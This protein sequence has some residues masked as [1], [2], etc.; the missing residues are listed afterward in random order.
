[1]YLPEACCDDC[2]RGLPCS[3]PGLG[4]AIDSRLEHATGLGLTLPSFISDVQQTL[5]FVPPAGMS[6]GLDIL[7]GVASGLDFVPGV[8]PLA[9][10]VVSIF[11]SALSSFDHWLHIG[12]GRSEADLIT[13][14]PNHIQ[15]QVMNQIKSISYVGLSSNSV[16]QLQA[17]IQELYQL[18]ASWL[19]FISNTSHFHDGRASEQAANTVMPYLDGT[20]GYHWPPPMNPGQ[21]EGCGGAWATDFGYGAG[22]L[23][24]LEKGLADRGGQVSP[25][26]ITQ[27]MSPF[28]P[29]LQTP[30]PG[31]PEIPQAGTLPPVSPIRTIQS[32]G[33]VPVGGLSS[34]A[35]LLLGAAGVLFLS[36]RGRS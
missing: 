10:S 22:L 2:L 7:N 24:A 34:S 16:Q 12:A 33:V 8:G 29:Y 1:M 6:Q 11:S 14:P 36:M 17:L 23:G 18:R 25:P 35:P 3:A 9:S 30:I 21:R 15:D 5:D 28:G 19:T 20:C 13:G 27:G 26:Q 4:F 31:L 32:A